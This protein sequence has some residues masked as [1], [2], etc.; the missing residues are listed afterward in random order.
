M[1]HNATF[2]GK[3]HIEFHT[4]AA[5]HFINIKTIFTQSL[6]LGGLVEDG[7]FVI[8]QNIAYIFY[9]NIHRDIQT[10]WLKILIKKIWR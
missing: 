6:A 1:R 2:E 5:A 3:S 7:D 9:Y 10:V 8:L 4:S